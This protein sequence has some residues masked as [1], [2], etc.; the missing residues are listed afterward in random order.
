M[1]RKI[2]NLHSIK[3]AQLRVSANPC[4]RSDLGSP[5]LRL[6]V[7]VQPSKIPLPQWFLPT[8]LGETINLV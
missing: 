1:T 5:E 4:L 2:V 7:E 8:D 3:S 6:E